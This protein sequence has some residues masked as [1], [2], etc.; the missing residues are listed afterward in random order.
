MRRTIPGALLLAL[1]IASPA[2]AQQRDTVFSWSKKL[3]DSSRFAI[4]SLNGAIEVQPASGD[5]VEVRATIRSD[6]RGLA[7][8]LSFDVRDT[9]DTAEICVV[10]TGENACESDDSRGDDHVAV[11]FVVELPRGLRLRLYTKNGNVI[12]M[13][14]ARE[15]D[16]A[17]T[18][19]GDVLIRESEG[20]ASASSGSGDVTVASA[21][22]AVRATSGNGRVTVNA[23]LGPVSA[24][25]GNGDVDV[26]LIS[27]ADTPGQPPM[28][29][30][31]GNGDVRLTL[32]ATFSGSI[33]A[34]TGRGSI[35]SAFDVTVSG[36]KEKSR[37]VG[38]IGR[39]TGPLIKLHSGNGRLEIRKD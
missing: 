18:G 8:D 5:R 6:A 16:A 37:L 31:S 17:T 33:D 7:R 19:S 28:S 10:D 27:V 38:T 20:R 9:S 3:P 30:S 39:G 23:A 32:P 4:R 13:Q 1:L 25:S 36:R 26:R 21:N 12:V 24:G 34:N 15:V 11:R 2:I 35:N 14:T 22:G 29:I